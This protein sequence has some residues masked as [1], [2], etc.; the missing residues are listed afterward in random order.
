MLFQKKLVY[1]F[2]ISPDISRLTGNKKD[3]KRIRTG[4]KLYASHSIQILEKTQTE[5]YL[6]FKEEF[7]EIRISQRSFESLKPF[8]V[9]P[10]RQKDRM[11]CCCRICLETK[12]LFKRCMDFRRI[13]LK[14]RTYLKMTN[15]EVQF[16]ITYMMLSTKRCVQKVR[17]KTHA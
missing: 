12:M 17:T 11:T 5:A 15:L 4:P 6:I 7:P 16:K 2:W 3:V 9:I 13:Y 1:N 10:V 8:F 14:H